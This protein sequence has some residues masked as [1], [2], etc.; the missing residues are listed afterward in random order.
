MIPTSEPMTEDPLPVV[1]KY[2]YNL[3]NFEVVKAGLNESNVVTLYSLAYAMQ[4]PK[5]LKDLKTF[6]LETCLTEINAPKFYL[7]GIRFNNTEIIA[8]C[9]ELITEN[10]DSLCSEGSE[11]IP[12]FLKDLPFER[13]TSLLTNSALKVTQE[14]FVL[15]LIE[16]Y[17]KH[18]E[19]LPLLAEEDPKN[20]WSLLNEE[21]RTKRLE[22]KKVADEE[23]K[24]A[25]EAKEA[26]K[27]A[28]YDAQED[29]G[30]IQSRMTDNCD[31]RIGECNARL[32]LSRLN[33]E[34]R[35][36][37]FKV[38]R[39]SYLP[40][41][42]L[43]KA[44]Q[45]KVFEEAKDFIVEGLSIRLNPLESIEEEKKANYIVNIEPRELYIP[46]E[47]RHIVLPDGSHIIDPALPQEPVFD[48]YG[49]EVLEQEG[50][51]DE[52]EELGAKDQ[53]TGLAA[54]GIDANTGLPVELPEGVTLT[55]PVTGYRTQFVDP[56]SKK[57]APDNGPITDQVT[58][59]HVRENEAFII[60]GAAVSSNRG[61]GL[62]G[63]QAAVNQQSF[64]QSQAI[65]Q[66]TG[67][68]AQPLHQAQ[69]QFPQAPA[70]A[71]PAQ[72]AYAQTNY[73][74]PMSYTPAPGVQPEPYPRPSGFG[75]QQQSATPQPQSFPLQTQPQFNQQPPMAQT[76]Y[77][78]NTQFDPR[79]T[80]DQSLNDRAMKTGFAT[81]TGARPP[82][83]DAQE[84][85][86]RVSTGPHRAYEVK[87]PEEFTYHFDFDDQGAL[88]FLG[89][90]GKSRVW[91]NPHTIGQV[92]SFA[93]SVGQGNI[94]NF[95]GRVPTNTRTANEPFSYFGVDLG[96]GR[97][98]MPSCYSIMNRNSTTHVL[99]NWH[100]EGSND[101]KEWIILDR[102]I[103]LSDNPYENYQLEE[104][105]K[106]LKKKGATSTWAINLDVS[107]QF[108]AR[109]FRYF[110][111]V[112]VGKNS[113]GSDNLALSGFEL[114]GKVCGGNW[115]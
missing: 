77:P 82:Q 78:Q 7:E 104:E 63:H 115:A 46:T 37:L 43:V 89:S 8:R 85:E 6:V 27:K 72:P 83:A 5:L 57:I 18:R 31:L 51:E 67:Q 106:L 71:A 36:D 33:K 3:Q 100:L 101:M 21:E 56:E 102:R 9:E 80:F 48:R 94:E 44:S 12:S 66:P 88:Y 70:Y 26:E 47:E 68:P 14:K 20:D 41:E 114:Y 103:Y 39:Y 97:L 28:E 38:V 90:Y 24:A 92:N 109:G 35:K 112:Q 111:L 30:K 60:K 54:T 107:K 4:M 52:P 110:R 81:A 75:Y 93:S 49:G 73:Q 105:Q 17:Q 23:T 65:I 34:Q 1:L 40:N 22:D 29:L 84:R 86:Q 98:L 76:Q 108:G 15:S 32:E 64:A 19:T 50:D 74:P 42:D 61:L 113:S 25:E 96:E 55:D 79:Q 58:G 91:Q 2:L 87:T 45:N 13:I 53:E 99:M 11:R 69:A 59:A 16:K 62:D 95:T 10:F